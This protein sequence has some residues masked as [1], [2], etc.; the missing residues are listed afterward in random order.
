MSLCSNVRGTKTISELNHGEAQKSGGSNDKRF[1]GT[2]LF[3][4]KTT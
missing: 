3:V 1:E 2:N 4:I